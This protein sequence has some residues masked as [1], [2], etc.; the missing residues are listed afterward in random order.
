[1][2]E[3]LTP[4]CNRRIGS[5]DVSDLLYDQITQFPGNQ[6]SSTMTC[7]PGQAITSWAIINLEAE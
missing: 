7:L 4:R 2:I 6:T 1:M 5:Q 3:S